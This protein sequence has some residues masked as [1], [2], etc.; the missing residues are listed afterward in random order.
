MD[1]SLTVFKPPRWWAEKEKYTY[2]NKTHRRMTFSSFD[3]LE[4]LLYSLSK[5]PKGGKKD[6]ELI[7]PA[8]YEEGTTRA[9]K[10][11]KGWAGC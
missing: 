10:N 2:D 6:A 4:K 1:I 5:Q 9:N 7:S 8:I 11:V 3:E